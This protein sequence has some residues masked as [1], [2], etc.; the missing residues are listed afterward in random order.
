MRK[1][2]FVELL[3]GIG[4]VLIA[5]NAIQALS[6][7]NPIAKITVLTFPPGGELLETDPLIHRVIYAEPGKAKQSVIELLTCETFDLIVSDTNY[8]D[9]DVEIRN[10]ASLHGASRIVTNLWRQPPPDERVGDRFVEILL[11]EGLIKQDAIKPA[12]L[13]LT[14][15][16]LN[17]AQKLFNHLHRPLV[18][19]CPDAGMA[20]KRWPEDNFITLGK[21]LQ[22][23]WNATVIVPVG[24]NLNQS[25]SIVEGIGKEAQILPRG[26]LRDLAAALACADLVVSADTGPARIAAALNVST[27]TL[28]GPSWHGRYGQPPPHVNLQGYPECSERNTSNFTVQQCWYSGICPLDKGWQ[29]CMEEISVDRV[30]GVVEGFLREKKVTR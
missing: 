19:F 27:I 1:I 10:F 8:D 12:Q 15:T 23:L 4:D 25:A 9:I 14:P 7:S 2:L 24:S 30:L 29:S 6:H 21:V 16:E 11:S 3:G 13:H 17:K 20:I 26:N 28:F 18:F 22:L 5:L